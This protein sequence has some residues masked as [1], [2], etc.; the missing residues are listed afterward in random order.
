MKN[1]TYD[2]LDVKATR[3]HEDYNAFKRGVKD[4]EVM[5]RNIINSAFETVTTVSAGIELLETFH[6]LAKRD[7]IKRTID[8]KTADLYALFI[9]VTN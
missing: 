5:M 7:T 4:L 9:A 3:W 2:I 6:Q 1:L 8:K